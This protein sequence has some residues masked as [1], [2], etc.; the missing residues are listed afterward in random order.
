MSQ[1]SHK[2]HRSSR[3]ARQEAPPFSPIAIHS[4]QVQI[5]GVGKVFLIKAGFF[6][7][8]CMP[9]FTFLPS[10]VNPP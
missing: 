1:R 2:N 5:F 8:R 3:L 10:T 6:P 4:E 7:S 9:V